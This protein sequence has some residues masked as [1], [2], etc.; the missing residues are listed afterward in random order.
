MATSRTVTN[1]IE[2]SDS[3]AEYKKRATSNT[4]V[5]ESDT[6]RTSLKKNGG[7]SWKSGRSSA[8]LGIQ[9]PNATVIKR[10]MARKRDDANPTHGSLIFNMF[11]GYRPLTA[12]KQ[13]TCVA[14]P[15]VEAVVAAR[16]LEGDVCCIIIHGLP[17][18]DG[19][20]NLKK[21]NQ[22]RNSHVTF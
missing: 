6:N 10:L 12:I 9:I 19:G 18:H 11:S 21:E 1:R 7:L 2:M 5:A 22:M 8:P 16:E 3:T 4:K 14:V 13:A 17:R 15:V 20:T